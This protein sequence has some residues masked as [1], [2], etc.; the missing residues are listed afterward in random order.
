MS[1]P[2]VTVVRL[3]MKMLIK[4]FRGDMSHESEAVR[5]V[6]QLL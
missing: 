6:D 5:R 1:I 2:S 4:R 3:S